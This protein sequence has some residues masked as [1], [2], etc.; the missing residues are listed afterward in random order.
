MLVD[1]F[2]SILQPSGGGEFVVIVS[3][4]PAEPGQAIGSYPNRRGKAD[5]AEE[6]KSVADRL[7]AELRVE[8]ERQGHRVRAINVRP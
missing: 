2:A 3:A 6:A 1:I 4:F 8:L 5:G 7:A